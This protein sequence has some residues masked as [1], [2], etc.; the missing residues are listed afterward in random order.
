MRI[1]DWSS[2]VCSSDLIVARFGDEA[3]Y[4]GGLSVR[5]T[6]DMRMQRLAEKALRDGLIA[7]DRRHGWRGPIAHIGGGPGWQERLADVERAPLIRDWRLAVVLDT[8]GGSATVG[9]TEAIGRAHVCTPVTNAQLVCRLL[10]EKKR[11]KIP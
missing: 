9:L 10:L 5:S 2:D 6:L 1:S 7:Y 8:S 11:K 4:E 3:L